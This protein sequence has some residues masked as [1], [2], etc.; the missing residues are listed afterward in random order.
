MRAFAARIALGVASLA[1]AVP[2]GGMCGALWGAKPPF[3]V[4]A[5]LWLAFE[6]G[7]AA[8]VPAAVF[9]GGAIDALSGAP[10]LCSVSMLLL[11]A[12]PALA[13]RKR[14]PGPG[15]AAGAGAT[16]CAAVFASIWMWLW[17][18]C[19][20]AFAGSAVLG[21]AS[22]AA[23]FA[24]L[25]FLRDSFALGRGAAAREGEEGGIGEEDG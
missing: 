25:R 1:I 5:F 10:V 16:A 11:A 19:A 20:V 13:L 8:A 2:A 23:V 21:A 15:A 12:L 18:G 9:A 7:M 24:A 17:T 14:I 6:Y 3:A 4:A 22:G